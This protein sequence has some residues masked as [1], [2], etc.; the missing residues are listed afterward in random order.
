MHLVFDLDETLISTR[1]A[2]FRAYVSCGIT[3]PVD[4]HVRPWQE[5]C[6][7]EQHEAKQDALPE[8]LPKLIRLLPCYTHIFAK[9]GGIVLTNASKRSLDTICRALPVVC[10]WN[11]LSEKTP[12]MKLEWLRKTP[13]GL[14]FDDNT[15]LIENIRRETRWQAVDVSGLSFLPQAT[16]NDSEML[17]T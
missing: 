7:H 4:F 12:A 10:S 14:Y 2:N 17:V 6:T 3:P 8:F 1:E 13:P 11:I 5:W 15:Q 9:T 16:R